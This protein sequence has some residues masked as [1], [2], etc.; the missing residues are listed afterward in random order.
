MTPKELKNWLRENSEIRY[1]DFTAKLLPGVNNIYGV[2]LPKLR[3]LAKQIALTQSKQFLK[4]AEDTSFEEIMLQGLTI[5][6]LKENTQDKQNLLTG[7]IPKINNWSVCDSTCASLKEAKKN[8]PS[9]WSWLQPLVSSE[10]EFA[11]RFGIVMLLFHFIE[12]NWI[13]NV[14]HL[15]NKETFSGYYAQMAAGWA[16]A[17]AYAKFPEKTLT[18]LHNNR[19]QPEVQNKAIRKICESLRT[20]SQE[21][22]LV[23]NLKK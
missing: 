21:K 4:T 22:Q 14:L 3:K 5:A 7:F 17:E 13:D 12:E 11:A 8:R 16:I 9:W 2:R 19:L 20:T 10:K 15:L 1:R 23:R 6:A 18:F